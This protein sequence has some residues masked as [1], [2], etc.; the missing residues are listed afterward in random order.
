[1][2][3]QEL[4]PEQRPSWSRYLMLYTYWIGRW[5]RGD[6]PTYCKTW[7]ISDY[8]IDFG[9]EDWN[10]FDYNDFIL[11]TED[12]GDGRL[13]I[14]MLSIDASATADLYWK[15]QLVASD[16]LNKV[17][18]SWTVTGIPPRAKIIEFTETLK[19]A[20]KIIEPPDVGGYW[21]LGFWVRKVRAIYDK[22]KADDHNIP[23]FVLRKARDIIGESL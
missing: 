5:I 22:V 17:G 19:C 7:K 18:L 21:I 3:D 9:F 20:D 13:K 12:L 23:V 1:M 2:P 10:D 4:P 15:D 8:V 6:D 11:R 14:T 16:L